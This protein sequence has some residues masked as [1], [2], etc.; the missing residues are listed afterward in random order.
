MTD[1][2]VIVVG[3]GIFGVCTA[4]HCQK[5]G[6]KTLLLEKFK[7][8][9][10]NGS[11]HG[12]S[13]I[14]RYAHAEKEY[15]PIVDDSYKQIAEL[16]QMRGEKLWKKTS[17]LWVSNDST[18]DSIATI[19]T[20]KKV[21]HEVLR[22]QE[23]G[24]RYPQFSFDEKWSGLVDPMGGVIYAD[25]WHNCF[26]DEFQK[27]GGVAKDEHEV[28]SFEDRD[29]VEVQTNN[30]TFCS[31]KVVFTVGVWLTQFL[32]DAPFK[33]QPVSI[34]VC[35]WKAKHP[36]DSK[37]L[38]EDNFPVFISSFANGDVHNFALPD[39][40][41]PG[42]IKFTQHTGDP[43]G[44]DLEHPETRSQKFIEMPAQ[45]IK[46]H[47]PVIDSQKPTVVDFCKYTVSEDEHYVIDYYPDEENVFIG[48]C[49]SGSGFKVAPAIGRGLAEMCAGKKTTND[50]SFFSYS[51]FL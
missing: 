47:L 29:F 49:G 6:L 31:R 13:R 50:F 41:Y 7:F 14:T 19:L 33:I 12:K 16:E 37:L 10:S 4:Y 9:H 26:L 8:G 44:T 32:P 18:V 21:E 35:Y 36:R 45:F 24:Q 20:E 15:V 27:L 3:A 23:I 39:T 17:L 30:G 22:G 38:N 25:K 46:N 48:G 5:L 51:R 43:L 40:D 42:S 1:Y 2:D 34:S 28:I 11:S